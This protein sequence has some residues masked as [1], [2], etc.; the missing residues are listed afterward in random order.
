MIGKNLHRKLIERVYEPPAQAAERL[1]YL[2][3][4]DLVE[5]NE[6]KHRFSRGKAIACILLATGSFLFLDYFVN[7]NP[8]L[9]YFLRG[10]PTR[11]ENPIYKKIPDLRE[12]RIKLDEPPSLDCV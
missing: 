9:K 6:P 4:S 1:S 8:D 7:V 10:Y 2:N 11:I 12:I 5:L 3:I